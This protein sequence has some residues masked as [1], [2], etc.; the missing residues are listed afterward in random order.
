[1]GTPR[2]ICNG[3][4]GPE[5][6]RVERKAAMSKRTIR[7]YNAIAFLICLMCGALYFV[8]SEW[9]LFS[10]QLQIFI[11]T[12]VGIGCISGALFPLFISPL[13]PRKPPDA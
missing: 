9:S 13:L 11:K 8:L 7:R 3:A 12:L 4:T 2:G 6:K 1:V 10:E 5:P